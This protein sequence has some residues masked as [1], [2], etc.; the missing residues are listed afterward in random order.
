MPF[1]L[2]II[3]FYTFT[4]SI[5]GRRERTQFNVANKIH[6]MNTKTFTESKIKPQEN[7]TNKTQTEQDRFVFCKCNASSFQPKNVS[8]MNAGVYEY[9]K[10]LLFICQIV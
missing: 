9:T 1:C 4:S 8:T 3:F 6:A 2:V 10:C 5:S 7:K